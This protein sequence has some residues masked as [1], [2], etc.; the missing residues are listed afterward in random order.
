MSYTITYNIPN[1][2]DIHFIETYIVPDPSLYIPKFLLLKMADYCYLKT[3]EKLD[4]P[5]LMEKL[6]YLIQGFKHIGFMNP[7]MEIKDIKEFVNQY[8]LNCKENDMVNLYNKMINVNEEGYAP[9]T[10]ME[11]VE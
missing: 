10:V 2:G 3:K 4:P 6:N 1:T 11:N 8:L 5:N 9:F 7:M